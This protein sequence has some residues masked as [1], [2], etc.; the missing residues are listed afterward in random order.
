MNSEEEVIKKRI[1]QAFKRC[2]VN[3]KLTQGELG[4]AIGLTQG[5]IS[6]IEVCDICITISYWAVFCEFSGTDI[7]S[8]F[9]DMP[10]FRR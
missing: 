2:R 3:K 7:D 9:V 8:A 6:K 10:D 1:S 4:K 5:H